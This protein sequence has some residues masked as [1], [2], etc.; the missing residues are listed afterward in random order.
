MTTQ[1]A[2][3]WPQKYLPGTGDNFVSN[4]VIVQGITAAD[5]WPFLTDTSTWEGYYDN[6]ADISFPDGGG[7]GLK[8]GLAFR[9]GTFGFPPLDARVVQFQAPA[10]GVPGR[11]SW[12][13]KQDGTPEERLDV[14]HAW[15]VEDL[16]GGRVRILTQETQI[17]R[18]AAALAAE[19]PNPMLNGH[20]AWLDGL[21]AAAS[22]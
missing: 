4:E 7:P 12:T 17:G 6:V 18:P 9:F 8:D 20:Q 10:E 1:H 2:I 5:V 11:L 16:P 14:L 15:L 19:R 13:A 21:V 3:D 22:R